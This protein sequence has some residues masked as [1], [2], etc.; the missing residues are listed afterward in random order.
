[1]DFLRNLNLASVLLCK[2]C[3]SVAFNRR[4][5]WTD[6]AG[7]HCAIL[8]WLYLFFAPPDTS[9]VVFDTRSKMAMS[10][11]G[12]AER[13][14]EKVRRIAWND[15]LLVKSV[16]NAGHGR[17]FTF[18]RLSDLVSSWERSCIFGSNKW[19]GLLN[20]LRQK[21]N[22]ENEL[23]M[24]LHPSFY[25]FFWINLSTRQAQ[26]LHYQLYQLF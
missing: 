20:I 19:A 26:T 11:G 10:Q 5:N 16:S 2:W 17:V 25:T 3:S 7:W 13:M 14:K 18:K 9:S 4:S 23:L 12:T 22:V 6:W 24:D 1:M 8:I 21:C 15:K